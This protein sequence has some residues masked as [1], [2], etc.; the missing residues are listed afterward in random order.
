MRWLST[1]PTCFTMPT[2]GSIGILA[3]KTQRSANNGG[4]TKQGREHQ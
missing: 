2:G 1:D 3:N 4:K